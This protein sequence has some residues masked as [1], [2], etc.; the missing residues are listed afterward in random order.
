[1]I[2]LSN[3]IVTDFSAHEWDA[4][5]TKQRKTVLAQTP[6]HVRNAWA[7]QAGEQWGAKYS[8]SSSPNIFGFLWN[9]FLW[10]GGLCL[11]FGL[12]IIIGFKTGFLYDPNETQFQ[13]DKAAGITHQGV[14]VEELNRRQNEEMMRQ[15]VNKQ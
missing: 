10:I 1:M 11:L 14:T 12:A 8:S 5:T 4:L 3:N 7:T 13:R 9:M 2:D 15:R 6:D